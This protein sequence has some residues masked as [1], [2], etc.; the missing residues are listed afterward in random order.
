MVTSKRSEDI[1][2]EIKV[3]LFPGI[4]IKPATLLY[5]N[6]PRGDCTNSIPVTP[7]LGAADNSSQQIPEML[8]T[9][10]GRFDP[11]RYWQIRYSCRIV[12]QRVLPRP[13]RRVQ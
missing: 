13:W 12:S 8:P 11:S 4:R 5:G 6:S 9:L 10:W 2:S 7:R 3:C 1:N